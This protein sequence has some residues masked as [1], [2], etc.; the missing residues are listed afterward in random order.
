M[1]SPG[2]TRIGDSF[3]T[4]PGGKGANQA[5][6]AVRLEAHVEMVGCVGDDEFG[7]VLRSKLETEGISTTWMGIE[8]GISSGIALIQ[9]DEKGENAITVVPGA[10]SRLDSVHLE[11]A[12]GV[13]NAAD[14]VLMQLE[15][16]NATVTKTIEICRK[17]GVLTVLDTAPAPDAG[18]PE[19][20]WQA[21]IVSPNQHEAE[22][23][24]GI[25]V[26]DDET[27]KQAAQALRTRGVR[28]VV[29]K[30]GPRG[31]FFLSE[32]GEMGRV[33]AYPADVIDT[34]AAGD[35][36]TAAMGI[37][38]AR[39]LGLREAVRFGCA[40]GSLAVCLPGAQDAMPAR[41]AVE[42]LFQSS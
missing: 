8:S 23:I 22:A 37:A 36:F 29:I 42:H 13:I 1:P 39:G 7:E 30:M 3:S 41:A 15:I 4:V 18:A 32:D 35:A 6:A 28:N 16:P 2:E 12:A 5:V 21:D 14:V 20:L 26:T 24:T 34:T 11:Y 17:A 10:N 19:M 40:A 9:V 27:A 25:K 31:A 38:L 33:P